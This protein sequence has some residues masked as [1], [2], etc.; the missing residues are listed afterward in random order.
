MS[1]K[2]FAIGFGVYKMGSSSKSHNF[3]RTCPKCGYGVCVL[4]AR[5]KDDERWAKLARGGR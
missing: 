4:R 5:K 1:L 3:T 2:A